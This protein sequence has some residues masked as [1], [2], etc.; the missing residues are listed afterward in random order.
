MPLPMK[1]F[2]INPSSE[3]YHSTLASWKV[4]ASNDGVVFDHIV[5]PNTTPFINN[6]LHKYTFPASANYAYWRFHTISMDN[7]VHAGISMLRWIPTLPEIFHPRKCLVG[8]VPR[9]VSNVNYSG[10]E[11]Y[12]SLSPRFVQESPF[13]TTV[14]SGFKAFKGDG[15]EFQWQPNRDIPPYWMSRPIT[16]PI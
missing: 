11:A 5:P 9:L 1:R 12:A 15:S 8:Y 2:H 13:A 10:F 3:T 16:C 6:T 4:Q 14:Q 7:A